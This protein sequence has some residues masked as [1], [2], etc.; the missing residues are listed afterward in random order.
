[1][2]RGAWQATVHGIPRVKHNLATKEREGWWGISSFVLCRDTCLKM[3]WIP[4]DTTAVKEAG[5]ESDN[6]TT[7]D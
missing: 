4:K 1:M 3:P 6:A 2:H 7:L 5:S